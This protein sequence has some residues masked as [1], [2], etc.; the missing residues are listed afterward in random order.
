MQHVLAIVAPV[1]GLIVLGALAGRFSW[2]GPETAKGLADFT[3]TLAVPAMLFRAM[4]TAN[5]PDVKLYQVWGAFFLAAGAVWLV[6]TLLTHVFL[7]R[8]S[9]DGAA[10]AM[11]SSFGNIVMLGLPLA[12]STFGPEAT[13]TTAVII[14]LHTPLLWMSASAHLAWVE[15]LREASLAS[16]LRGVL[17]ELSRNTIILAILGGTLW[18]LTEWEIDP[19]FM[20]LLTLLGNAAVPC[21]L[22]SLG[23]SLVGFRIKGQAATL[24][25]ILILK[26]LAMPLIAWLLAAHVFL[27]PPVA[28]GVVVLFAAM[29]TGA[30]AYLFASKNGTAVNSASGA[31]ALGTCIS[32]VTAAAIIYMLKI[33]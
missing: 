19:L 33:N 15:R 4:A 28:T 20:K 1:F 27:L 23:L 17:G 18:R 32:V 22:V 7:H 9:K 25:S 31:G 24:L 12:L 16:L 2:V 30:N 3:F 11:S 8:P 14:S 29:P 10:I 13:A 26:M 6:A 5:L 21:A